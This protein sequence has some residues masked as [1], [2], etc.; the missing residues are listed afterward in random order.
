MSN[1]NIADVKEKVTDILANHIQMFI[2]FNFEYC[3]DF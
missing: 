3:N 2:K 1:T